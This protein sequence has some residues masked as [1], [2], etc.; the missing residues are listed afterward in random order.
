MREVGRLPLD[1]VELRAPRLVQPRDGV[2]QPQ[3]VGMPRVAIDIR[4][5]ASFDDLA[6]IHDVDAI[7]VAGHHAEVVRDDEHGDA[8]LLR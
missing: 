3:G 7:G 1:R 5:R 8:V 6:G 4:R 2:E